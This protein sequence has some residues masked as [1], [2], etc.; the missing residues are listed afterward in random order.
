MLYIKVSFSR[1]SIVG[2]IKLLFNGAENIQAASV[3]RYSR[4]ENFPKEHYKFKA[5]YNQNILPKLAA[6]ERERVDT[7][8]I[9]RKNA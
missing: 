4:I 6:F 9:F 3:Y 8:K 7:L 2:F 5:Y 1:K